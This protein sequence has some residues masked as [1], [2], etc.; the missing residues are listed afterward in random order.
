MTYSDKIQ[1]RLEG[2][3]AIQDVIDLCALWWEESKFFKTYGVEYAPDKK[4]FESMADAGI[5]LILCGRIGGELV[6]VYAA[7]TVPYQFNRKYKVCSEIVWCVHPDHQRGG[8]MV[9]LLK[10]VKDVWREYDVDF[11]SLAVPQEPKYK[12]VVEYL[13]AEGFTNID[14]ILFYGGGVNG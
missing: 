4:L 7:Y 14:N 9:D 2:P 13:E 5:L 11:G 10:A 1:F 8:I 6:A 3:E 12:A